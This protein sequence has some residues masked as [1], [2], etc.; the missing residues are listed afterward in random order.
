MKTKPFNKTTFVLISLLLM[1]KILTLLTLSLVCGLCHAQGFIDHI[2][3]RG[4]T[5]EFLA[6]KFGV[7]EQD[8]RD[9][10]DDFD[11]D[12]LYVGLPLQIPIPEIGDSPEEI[13]RLI[14]ARSLT[15]SILNEANLLYANGSYRKA[16]KLYTAAIKENATSEIYYLRGRCYLHQGKYKSAVKDLELANAG[17]DLPYSLKTSCES[18]L[19][20]AHDKREA[21]LE[22]RGELFGSI[23][24]IAA[25]STATVATANAADNHDYARSTSS[26]YTSSQGY[27]LPPE[28]QPEIAARNAVAQMNYQMKAEEEN[29]KANYRM[30]FKRNW[31]REPSDIEV[32]EAYTNYLKT[33]N[34]AYAASNSSSTSSS[35]SSTISTT[36]TNSTSNTSTSTVKTCLKLS[37]TDDTHCNGMK[38]CSKC[39]GKKAYWDN[40]FGYRHYVDP[41]M[42]CGGSGK[43]PSCGGTG[44]KY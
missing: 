26:P 33:K 42:I 13:E 31:G 30:T 24:A 10:N 32:M 43:C 6:S 34:D 15:S 39:N 29:F 19:A 1:S 7:S 12:I 20:E 4:E 44:V 22:A 2:V 5:L 28:L 40:S 8:I 37:A 38:V 16:A 17:G 23:F 35:T 41:C 36:S 14:A 3:Q 11:L 25:V 21:Q 27:N 18:L 9:Q